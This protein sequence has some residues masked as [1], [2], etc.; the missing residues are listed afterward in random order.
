MFHKDQPHLPESQRYV[1]IS[2][3]HWLRHAEPGTVGYHTKYD[4]RINQRGDIE[5]RRLGGSWQWDGSP[6]P[7]DNEVR[8]AITKLWPNHFDDQEGDIWFVS[9][10]SS[11]ILWSR[12]GSVLILD[13]KYR[14]V[15]YKEPLSITTISVDD[16]P[17]WTNRVAR[18]FWPELFEKVNTPI[19][20]VPA[21][22]EALEQPAPKNPL[23]PST[24]WSFKA[25]IER[26][27]IS[28]I[29]REAFAAG[30]REVTFTIPGLRPVTCIHREVWGLCRAYATASRLA[31]SEEGMDLTQPDWL[32]VP[33]GP[34]LAAARKWREKNPKPVYHRVTVVGVK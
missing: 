3:H 7:L 24:H 8:K 4:Y 32:G 18:H 15:R 31:Y 16:G 23:E 19:V 17:I 28:R 34:I 27:D 10:E 14:C 22:I 21:S 1:S 2:G 11:D 29:L 12:R 9:S 25:P 20:G 30:A 13:R 26:V 33:C 6:G 5:I